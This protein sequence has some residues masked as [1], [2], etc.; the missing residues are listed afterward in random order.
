MPVLGAVAKRFS[1]SFEVLSNRFIKCTDERAIPVYWDN[2]FLKYE[3]RSKNAILT[4]TKV[5]RTRDPQEPLP[6]ARSRNERG[7]GT[8]R[9][10][11]ARIRLVCNRGSAHEAA[12]VQTQLHGT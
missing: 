6:D 4:R 5:R 7:S 8:R 1:V 3:W 10:R 12:R 11:N 2:G 9:C